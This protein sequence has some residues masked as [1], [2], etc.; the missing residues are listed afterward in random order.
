MHDDNHT[1]IRHIMLYH[2]EKGWKE[3]SHFATQRANERGR[4][5][6]FDDQALFATVKGDES[7]TTRMLADN[8]NVNHR[9]IIEAVI[10]VYG[11]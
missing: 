3:R 10:E 6:D 5:S 2:F 7:L 11:D 1:R 8:F 9:S 4:L